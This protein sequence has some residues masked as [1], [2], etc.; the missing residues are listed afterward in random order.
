[1]RKESICDIIDRKIIEH[2]SISSSICDIQ[3][4]LSLKARNF[5]KVFEN[6]N[7]DSSIYELLSKDFDE[8][9]PAKLR[10]QI[11]YIKHCLSRIE[12]LSWMARNKSNFQGLTM[13]KFFNLIKLRDKL[14][15]KN[16]LPF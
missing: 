12:D 9:G 6:N 5:V 1:M 3:S 2:F 4:E 10:Y 7:K 14:S 13:L 8:L 16:T 15:N 11:T